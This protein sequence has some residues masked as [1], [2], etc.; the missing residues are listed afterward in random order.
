MCIF[1]PQL[2]NNCILTKLIN[3]NEEKPTNVS[4]A[5]PCHGRMGT[6]GCN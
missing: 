1:L 6:D 4:S 2:S 5:A 3:H